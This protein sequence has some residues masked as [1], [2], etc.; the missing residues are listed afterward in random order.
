MGN[1]SSSQNS[2]ISLDDLDSPAYQTPIE[3]QILH[4]RGQTGVTEAEKA[5]DIIRRVFPNA[6]I[7]LQAPEGIKN[8]VIQHRNCTLFNRNLGDGYLNQNT[9]KTFVKKL[10]DAVERTEINNWTCQQCIREDEDDSV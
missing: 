2:E 3:I 4:C 7:N 6:T 9:A 1:T 8:L 5:I 10:K